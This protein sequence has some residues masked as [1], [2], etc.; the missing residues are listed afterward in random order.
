MGSDDTTQLVSIVVPVYNGEKHLAQCIE[1]LLAQTYSNIELICVDDGSTDGSLAIL[2][3]HAKND[4]RVKVIHQEN[5]G[6]GRA[7]NVGISHAKGEFIYFFD[8]DDWCAPELIASAVERAVATDAQVVVLPFYSV[9][10]RVGTPI[11][12]SWALLRDKY[13]ADVFSWKDNPGWLYEAFSNLPWVKLMR[14]S[15]VKDNSIQFEEDVR[16]TEDLLFAVKALT[17]A[18]RI[19]YTSDALIYHREGTGDN[20]MARKDKHPLDFIT[21]FTT[22]KAWLEE[23]GHYESLKEAFLNWAVDGCRYNLSDLNTLNAYK[24]VSEALVNGGFDALGLSDAPEGIWH[25]KEHT[26]FIKGVQDNSLSYL[27]GLYVENRQALS[28]ERCWSETERQNTRAQE[29]RANEALA[30]LSNKQEQ[31]RQSENRVQDMQ[32]E[33]ANLK[34]QLQQLQALY[35]EQMNSAEHKIGTAICKAPRAVQRK[36]LASK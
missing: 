26:E 29:A 8:C 15:F 5:A 33:C 1:S 24:E 23:S 27:Y 2:E 28:A 25:Y 7:R 13:P 12:A 3:S 32:Q 19:S 31:L 21:A 30:Q 18:E 14:T 9:D 10:E 4:S 16:L 6:P 34:E 11:L 36:L 35:D 20:T 22:T 17:L